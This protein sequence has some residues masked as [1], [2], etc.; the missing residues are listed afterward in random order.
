MHIDHTCLP[1][2]PLVP[3]TKYTKFTLC[4]LHTRWRVFKLPVANP[5]KKTE[6]SLCLLHP[7]PPPKPSSVKNDPSASFSQFLGP[8]K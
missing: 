2:L 6:S 5:L 3:P 4:C 8:L 7:S 1:F